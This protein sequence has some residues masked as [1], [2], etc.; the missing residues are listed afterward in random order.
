MV[1]DR[2]DWI[3]QTKVKAESKRMDIKIRRRNSNEMGKGIY[4]K[5]KSH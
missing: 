3:I 4:G 2:A 5:G 1:W